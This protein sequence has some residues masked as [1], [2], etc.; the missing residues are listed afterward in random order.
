[1]AALGCG[2]PSDIY[3][4]ASDQRGNLPQSSTLNILQPDLFGLCRPSRESLHALVLA[5]PILMGAYGTALDCGRSMAIAAG[6]DALHYFNR[7]LRVA[8][9]VT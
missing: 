9:N 8:F 7:R 5:E 1:M 4:D 3:L 2:Q 6:R